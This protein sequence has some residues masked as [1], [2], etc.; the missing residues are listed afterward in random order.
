MMPEKPAET[1]FPVHDLIRRRW[2]PRAF[3]DKPV[4]AAQLGSLLEAVRWA[5]SSNNEQ[6]WHFI[7]VTKDRPQEFAALWDCLNPS[8]QVWAKQAPVLMLS[9]ARLAFDDGKAN[10]HA[11]HDVGQA[12]ANLAIQATALG[13]VVHQM[14]GFSVEKARQAFGIPDGFE[15]VAAIAVGYQGDAK[16]LPD[17]LRERELAPR[18]REPLAAMASSGRWGTPPDFLMERS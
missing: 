2:S 9:V 14:A 6:P 7:V 16:E 4:E 15:P 5:A 18:S 17:R 1:Q 10:R 3:A 13:L 8:N 11:L 12:A